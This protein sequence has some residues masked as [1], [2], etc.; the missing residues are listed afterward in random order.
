MKE[1]SN[2]AWWADNGR[3]ILS[4]LLVK[5]D[6]DPQVACSSAEGA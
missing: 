5:S 1:E 4:Q 6:K 3:T 2:R